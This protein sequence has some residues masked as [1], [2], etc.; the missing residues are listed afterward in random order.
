[1]E[2]LFSLPQGFKVAPPIDKSRKFVVPYAELK[3]KKLSP[4]AIKMYLACPFRFYLRYALNM[5]VNDYM[6]DELDAL[7]VGTFMHKIW[8]NFAASEF[9]DSGRR[10]GD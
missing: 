4:S 1:M 5:N 6:R 10:E 3:E 2:K 9:K 8:E 7:S